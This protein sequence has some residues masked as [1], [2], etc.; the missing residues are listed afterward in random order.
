M[1]LSPGVGEEDS[2]AAVA[3]H[4]TLHTARLRRHQQPLASGITGL[5][6]AN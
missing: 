4:C 6:T 1:Y 5:K 2:R 3:A